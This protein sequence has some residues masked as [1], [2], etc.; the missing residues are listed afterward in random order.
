M[1]PRR[2]Y[3]LCATPRSGSTLLCSLLRS[4]GVAGQPESWFRRQ[5]RAD[6][7]RE[8][9]IARADGSYDWASYLTAA[10]V[11]GT[12]PNGVC[13]LRLMWNM[14]EELTAELGDE[15]PRHQAGLM[16]ASFGPLQFLL[17]SRRDLVAQAV[18]RHRAEVS[19]TWHLGFEEVIHPAEPHYDGAMIRR[20]LN[21]A[22]EDNAAWDGWFK[23]ND[24]TPYRITY[25]DLSA[26]PVDTAEAVLAFLGLDHVTRPL[27]AANRRMADDV[28]AVWVARYKAE[29]KPE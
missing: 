11:A 15:P 22:V 8:W 25:E 12:G 3:V 23:A 21:E 27:R 16:A 10:L 24:I 28:S 18:S 5:D 6:W 19:G 14:L 4:S 13:G 2:T 29:A 20:Y 26:A 1:T 9:S 17:L 7:A